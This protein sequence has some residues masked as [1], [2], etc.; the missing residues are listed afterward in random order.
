MCKLITM[1]ALFAL[2]FLSSTLFGELDY[3]ALLNTYPKAF[4]RDGS[5]KQGE[6]EVA[7]TKGEIQRI[8]KLC[9]QRFIRMGYSDS[10]AEKS[11]RI[12]VIAE[13]H[14]WLWV[15]DAVI[16]PGGIPG[17]YNRIIWKSGLTGPQGV[18]IFP[19]LPNKKVL[20]N[21]N[22]RHAI[23]SWE[24]ELP[25]GARN[26]G[27]LAEQTAMRELKEETGC[28][29]KKMTC[30]GEMC[31]DSGI[32][33]GIVPIYMGEIANKV[34]RHQDESEAIALNVEMTID[35]IREAFVKGY[36]ITEIRGVKTKVYC[37][38]PF[39]SFALLQAIWK[40]VL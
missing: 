38:D 22:F 5:W 13:D 14:Y 19:V 21:I 12:G 3:H 23:R 32:I 37:R 31:P 28:T 16:F 4:G 8:Q 20:L 7:S 34:E 2:L 17:T 35:E 29:V 26:E 39:L 9:K 1:K 18:A 25:R 33:G 24:L 6:I 15:R 27:E 10:D 11:A 36:I 30:L 40:K